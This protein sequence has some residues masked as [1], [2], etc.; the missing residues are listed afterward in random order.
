MVLLDAV[1]RHDTDSIVCESQSQHDADHPMRLE[2]ALDAVAGVEYAAQAVALH[3]A[4]CVADSGGVPRQGYL[5][6]VR[7]LKLSAL[8]LDACP[9]ALQ[10]AAHCLAADENNAVYAFAVHAGE[11]EL[12]SGRMSVVLAEAAAQEES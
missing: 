10:I 9:G 11:Q 12:L 8:W 5:G 7:A 3:R 2:G 4:L 1:L 6:S